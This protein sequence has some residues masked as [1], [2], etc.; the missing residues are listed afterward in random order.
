MYKKLLDLLAIDPFHPAQR[1]TMDQI[2]FTI[3]LI[4]LA[5]FGTWIGSRIQMYAVQKFESSCMADLSNTCFR[6]LHNHSYKFF[7]D[8]YAGSLIKRVNRFPVCFE[9]VADQF[10]LQFGPITIRI[11]LLLGIM[12][13]RNKQLGYA[14][15]TWTIVFVCYNILFSRYRLKY[16]LRR[17]E[18]DSKVT[19]RLSDTISNNINLKL[20]AGI[21][22][23]NSSFKN[24]TDEHRHARYFSWNLYERSNWFQGLSIIILEAI[25]I[26]MAV[27]YWSRG[28]LT[29]GDFILLRFYFRDLVNKVQEISGSVRKLYEA[30]ADANEMTEILLTKHEIC[31][32]EDA[33]PLVVQAGEIEFHNVQFRYTGNAN[34]VLKDFNLR[35]KAGERIG[36]VGS[37][38]GGKST[39][40]KLL[41]RLHDVTDGMILIDNQDITQVTQSSLHRSIAY[42]PQD[43]ILFHRTLMENIRYSRPEATD[44][45]VVH[46]AKLAHC[47]E[48][49][50]SFPQG[51]E[52]LVG[53]RGI[54]LSGGERQRV[55]IARAI[56][57]NA[58]IIVLDEAT[59][60]LD[61]ESE[62]L[63]Q[64][65]LSK[66]VAGRTVFAVAHR[67][68]TIRKMDR[69]FV[70]TNGQIVEEGN[71]DLLLKIKDG[72]Y[73]KLWELQ[74]MDSSEDKN[75]Q[76]QGY[77]Q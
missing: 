67:L 43:P 49:I 3:R 37:S 45:E 29:L 48:F 73:Q 54:K 10:F 76:T 59:S 72:T 15:L 50:S 53:E 19:G 46:A 47:H 57:M 7:S 38:G 9:M 36:I 12:F 13:S 55:A 11:V 1:G 42:V 77:L 63:I 14:L 65:A 74:T 75:D 5:A 4:V 64:D 27:T 52:T 20:F 24:L 26:T 16:D 66:L 23:E 51:Y 56:L 25:M 21:E 33:L 30:M 31:D 34:L 2:Y 60:S 39:I 32:I 28:I 71:H 62:V 41:V 69:I 58:P 35:T 6:Y 70:V 61:S 8:N 18:L 68:S 44:E 22:R 40:L 17:A